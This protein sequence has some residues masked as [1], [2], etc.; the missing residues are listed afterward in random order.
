MI[1]FGV[2]VHGSA[3]TTCA[4]VFGS[5][6]ILWQKQIITH[7]HREAG[8]D[9]DRA[10]QSPCQPHSGLGFIL[11]NLAPTASLS[12]LAV[13]GLRLWR[14]RCN[15]QVQ[16][17]Q[18]WNETES[19]EKTALEIFLL[20]SST[21]ILH[22]RFQISPEGTILGCLLCLCLLSEPNKGHH[23]GFHLLLFVFLWR[24][25][26]TQRLSYL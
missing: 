4:S 5:K 19:L 18:R 16:W 24:A 22:R 26:M 23:R 13:Q 12:P 20:L 25:K 2:C 15:K 9:P 3:S 1:W 21:V 14:N 8:A 11:D 10:H 7:N 17:Q 6:S